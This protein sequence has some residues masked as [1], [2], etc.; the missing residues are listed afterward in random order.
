MDI[1]IHPL[2]DNPTA[3]WK[4]LSKQQK[5]IKI[6]AKPPTTDAPNDKV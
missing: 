1:D 4:E 5:V 6:N 3:A 2:T